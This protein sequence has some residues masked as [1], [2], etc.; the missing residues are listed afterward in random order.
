M[1]EQ[2]RFVY[3]FR[4]YLVSDLGRVSNITKDVCLKQSTDKDGYKGV[5]L[6]ENGKGKKFKVHQLVYFAF[7]DL[8]DYISGHVID[9]IN[10]I[11]S[12]NRFENLQL[13]TIR[14][15]N[16]KD[17]FRLKRTSKYIGVYWHKHAKKWHAQTSVSKKR[18]HLGYFD[19]EIDAHKA[20]KDY[21]SCL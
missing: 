7:S 8:R 20:Y 11:K 2:W 21:L 12:D 18:I 3:E 13:I 6:C 17:K 10:N 19:N 16:S 4:N 1:K 14:E 5:Y 15:N 9:H